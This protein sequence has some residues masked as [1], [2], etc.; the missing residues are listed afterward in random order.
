M[1]NIDTKEVAKFRFM[2]SRIHSS[3]CHVYIRRNYVS[4]MDLQITDFMKG[5][6][7]SISRIKSSWLK[8]DE[9]PVLG[10]QEVSESDFNDAFIAAANC[11]LEITKKLSTKRQRKSAL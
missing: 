8:E 6:E 7:F 4:G 2:M 1:I 10:Y 9:L 5:E 3:G 11:I